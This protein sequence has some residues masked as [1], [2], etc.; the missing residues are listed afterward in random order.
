MSRRANGEGSEPV[1]RRDGRWAVSVRYI[2][3]DGLSR[4]TSVYGKTAKEA[5]GKAE[6]IRR[7][8]RRRRPPKDSKMT[9]AAFTTEWICSTLAVSDRKSSTRS[10]YAT[11]AR[12]HIVDSD[13]GRSALDRLTARKV[14][15]WISE[16][17][18]KGLAEST[19]RSAYTVLRAVLDTAVRDRA[20]AENPAAV[21]KR[22]KVTS[23]EAPVLTEDQVEQVLGEAVTS[24][25]ALLFEM[26]VYT[27][28]R[29]GE[30]LALRWVDVDRKNRRLRV[31]GTLTREGGVLVVT[32]VKTAKSNRTLPLTDETAAIIDLLRER[33]E[34]EREQAGSMWVES[35]FIFTTE[36]GAPSDPR[37]ALRAFKAAA[38]RAG[39]SGVG[40]HTL[41]HTGA[42]V[43]LANGV[44]LKVV[45]E[46][47]G[48]SSVAVTGDVYG[49][50]APELAVTA[51][52][53]I[54]GA[55][56]RNGGQE[57]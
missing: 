22:P 12:K 32:D 1:R 46:L 33:Q 20:I 48:H 50:V 25:Y 36:F 23:K 40:L 6:E 28:M 9:L 42:S 53:K 54:S 5:R 3:P 52:E 8:L 24:R 18:K 21:V 31:R 19:V 10:M 4:R 51:M 17:R 44:P 15:A 27:G 45:S 16:L 38:D 34:V 37:N 2:D 30:A 55:F 43:A 13:L 35:G 41:R 56:R 26:L 14:E 47:W 7:R 29:R 57:R 11:L 39:I 49:H